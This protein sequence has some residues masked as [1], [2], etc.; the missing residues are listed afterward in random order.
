MAGLFSLSVRYPFAVRF[1][2]TA[3]FTITDQ[4]YR[5]G[6]AVNQWRVRVVL[7]D[8]VLAE[9]TSPGWSGAP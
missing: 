4:A 6:G 5:L 2:R 7:G 1:R 8:R 9:R 3:T